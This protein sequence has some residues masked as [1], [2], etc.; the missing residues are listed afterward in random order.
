MTLK[1]IHD[2]N[3]FVKKSRKFCANERFRKI[4]DKLKKQTTTITSIRFFP[5]GLRIRNCYV[6]Y[7][8]PSN[9]HTYFAFKFSMGMVDIIT[10][11]KTTKIH[12]IQND[13]T[14]NSAFI[15][16][17]LPTDFKIDY[18][19]C[20]LEKN[21]FSKH[22]AHAKLESSVHKKWLNILV[23]LVIYCLVVKKIII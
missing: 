9:Y 23:S 4:S 8:L 3:I 20:R 14:E 16:D 2:W 1:K 12:V 13:D 21:C 18:R 10:L 22:A 5:A 17:L 11:K 6:A 15:L 7:S 19:C